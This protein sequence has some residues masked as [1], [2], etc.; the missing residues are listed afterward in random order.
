MKTTID[1]ANIPPELLDDYL[2][3]GRKVSQATLEIDNECDA[4]RQVIH[5]KHKLEAK[6]K[7]DDADRINPIPRLQ[8]TPKQLAL[9]EKAIASDKGLGD[10]VARLIESGT[11]R[12]MAEAGAALSEEFGVITTWVRAVKYLLG[13]DCK[14]CGI[15]QDKWNLLYPF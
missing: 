15:N 11:W 4:Y 14:T 6:P 1:I 5:K 3:F 13:K 12:E 2:A 7:S 9:A 8:W 10:V